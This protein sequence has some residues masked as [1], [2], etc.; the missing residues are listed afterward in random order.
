[1]EYNPKYVKNLDHR[2]C[3]DAYRYPQPM[4]KGDSADFDKEIILSPYIYYYYIKLDKQVLEFFP[5]KL[6]L[7]F[8]KFISYSHDIFFSELEIPLTA[9]SLCYFESLHGRGTNLAN[10]YR[11]F[12][13]FHSPWA[14]SSGVDFK[15]CL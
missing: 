6:A 4:R 11:Y 14:R 3:Q 9:S 7:I 15:L 10:F 2:Y 8:K 12:P 5:G 13:S 1:M